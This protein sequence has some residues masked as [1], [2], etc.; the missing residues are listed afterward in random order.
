[1]ATLE[2]KCDNAFNMH[3]SVFVDD[4]K[5]THLFQVEEGPS[6]TSYG[7]EIAQ[8]A[9]FPEKILKRARDQN[10]TEQWTENICAKVCYNLI[11]PI[12]SLKIKVTDHEIRSDA[13]QSLRKILKLAKE[14]S[15][16]ENIKAEAMEISK[17]NTLL[18]AALQ[19]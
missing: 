13:V 10:E 9:G 6:S 3:T 7:I 15:S 18:T 16:L 4:N 12:S 19:N 11:P 1:M 5:V 14:S 17:Q 8:L 2:S